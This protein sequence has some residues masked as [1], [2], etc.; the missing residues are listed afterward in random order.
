[1]DS[2]VL[3]KLVKAARTGG[4]TY[5]VSRAQPITELNEWCFPRW[6]D[7]TKIVEESRLKSA[8]AVFLQRYATTLQSEDVLLGVWKSDGRYYIDMN[9]HVARFEDARRLAQRYSRESKRSIISAYNPATQET[10]YFSS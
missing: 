2:T 9:A 10:R 7:R 4:V 5:D 8:L 3:D 1:M 6:P